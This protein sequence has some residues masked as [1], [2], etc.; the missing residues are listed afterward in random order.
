[1]LQLSDDE[2]LRPAADR[3]L[4]RRN[5]ARQLVV[6]NEKRPVLA[7]SGVFSQAA[8]SAQAHAAQGAVAP[9]LVPQRHERMQAREDQDKGAC[10]PAQLGDKAGRPWTGAVRAVIQ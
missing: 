1:M 3:V 5:K 2:N 8:A 6:R 9:E 7:G 4:K 10:V